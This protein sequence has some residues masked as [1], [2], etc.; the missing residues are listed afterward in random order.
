MGRRSLFPEEPCLVLGHRGASGAFP[1][2][3]LPAFAG[4][5]AAGAD[6]VELDVRVT[7][8]GVGVAF[9]DPDVSRTTNGRGLV[10]EMSWEQVAALEIAIPGGV[11][12]VPSLEQ[13]VAAVGE[14][15]ALMFEVKN[16][17]GQPGYDAVREPAVEAILAALE[18]SEAP[19]VIASFNPRNIERCREL[20]RGRVETGFISTAAMDPLSGLA[21]AASAGHAWIVPNV[22][23]VKSAGEELL[24]RARAADVR[25][26][27][28]VVDDPDDVELLVS[29][30]V[31]ALI[32]NVP[33][34]VV[35][36]RDALR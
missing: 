11:T 24:I 34:D 8:D 21:Y 9:H 25:V 10:H 4:A 13:V 19:S 20:S 15:S 36:L 12:G 30:G 14:H 31:D 22:E 1:E 35:P 7:A 17:P 6:G 2:N 32:T 29:W 18:G 5:L 28:W 26:G 27:V 16:F 33:D 3:T 23:A